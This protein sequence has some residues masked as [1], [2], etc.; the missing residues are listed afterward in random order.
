MAKF[1]IKRLLSIIPL[2]FLVVF[3]VFAVINIVPGDPGRTILGISAKQEDVDA[4]NEELGY[5]DP[6]IVK[7]FRYV[8]NVVTKFD[9]GNSYTSGRPVV[10]EIAD[11]FIYTFR[12]TIF[13]VFFYALI[14]I[15]LG[16]ISA[17]KQYSVTDNVI[18][19]L[20]MLIAAFPSFWLYM[21]GMLVFSLWLGWLPS[22]GVDSWVNYILPVGLFAISSAAGLARTTRTTMLEAIRQDYVRTARAKGSSERTVIWTHAFRNAMLPIINAIGISIGAMMGGTLITEQ[23]FAM[24][25]LGNL[26]YVAIQS[27]DVP[28]VMGVTIFLSAVF[29]FMVLVVDVV[30]AFVD[31]R[32][33]AKYTR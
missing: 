7:F 16:V 2:L 30:S 25:G 19:V 21:L 12:I 15:P 4:K 32:V 14:G 27:H 5:Y 3:L 29:C 1:V 20:A 9:F 24:P 18:R 28:M 26:A 10:S 33:R 22:S 13:S 17:V 31:P 23:I 8:K 11:N 6:F